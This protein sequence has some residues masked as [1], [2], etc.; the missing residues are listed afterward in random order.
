MVLELN[1]KL[2]LVIIFMLN[3]LNRTLPAFGPNV[4]K[5]STED[6]L[7]ITTVAKIVEIKV[8]PIEKRNC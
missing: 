4:E 8:D 7:K 1:S 3:S 6:K 5:Y 2:F